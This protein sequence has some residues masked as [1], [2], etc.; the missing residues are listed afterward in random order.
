MCVSAAVFAVAGA[1]AALSVGGAVLGNKQAKDAYEDAIE[2]ERLNL[3]ATDA[4]NHRAAVSAND[5]ALEATTDRARQ[6]VAELGSLRVAAGELGATGRSAALLT[7]GT[8][9]AAGADKGRIESNRQGQIQQ[10]KADSR[11]GRRSFLS[12]TTLALN[13]T[14]ATVLSNNLSAAGSLLKAGGN[15]ALQGNRLNQ[16]QNKGP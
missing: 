9:Y 3:L 10:I 7:A 14:R 12:N 11:A 8:A 5:Q 4:E 1:Q 16:A 13:T 15:A 2:A 6:A